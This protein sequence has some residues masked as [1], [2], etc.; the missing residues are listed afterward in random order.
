M[1]YWKDILGLCGA[2][3]VVAGFAM[4]YQPLAFIVGGAAAI[5]IA[6]LGA[7]HARTD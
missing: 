5:G 7:R 1:K 4:I 6:I 2:A 3:C